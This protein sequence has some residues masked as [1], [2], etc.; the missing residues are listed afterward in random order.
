MTVIFHDLWVMY[1]GQVVS[2]EK[3]HGMVLQD[4]WW[5]RHVTIRDRRE[6]QVSVVAL[7]FVTKKLGRKAPIEWSEKEA[8]DPDLLCPLRAWYQ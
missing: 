7:N 4:P 1:K 8:G 6:S 3:H 2:S 5:E